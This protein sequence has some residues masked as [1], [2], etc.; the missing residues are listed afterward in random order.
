MTAKKVYTVQQ[1]W[2][3]I[4][5]LMEKSITKVMAVLKLEVRLRVTY[6]LTNIHISIFPSNVSSVGMARNV[7]VEIHNDCGQQ[8]EVQSEAAVQYEVEG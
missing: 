8:A 1:M 6:S 2:L 3:L 5:T 4:F 7:L